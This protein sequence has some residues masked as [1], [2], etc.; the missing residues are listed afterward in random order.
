VG[1]I[2]EAQW[3]IGPAF[4]VGLIFFAFDT[5]KIE[6][7]MNSIQASLSRRPFK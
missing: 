4:C 3:D 6:N 1:W 2:L 7:D 5:I